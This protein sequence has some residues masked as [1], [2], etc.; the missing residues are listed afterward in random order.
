MTLTEFIDHYNWVLSR[1]VIT[2]TELKSDEDN[3]KL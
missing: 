2:L 3:R 1:P